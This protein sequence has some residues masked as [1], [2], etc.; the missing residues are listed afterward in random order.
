MTNLKTLVVRI[1]ADSPSRRSFQDSQGFL[2][3]TPFVVGTMAQLLINTRQKV[4]VRLEG[5]AQSP[6]ADGS[7]HD[8]DVYMTNPL[9]MKNI[10]N[11][12]FENHKRRIQTLSISERSLKK[13][14]RALWLIQGTDRRFRSSRSS[15]GT[16]NYENPAT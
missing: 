11:I 1:Q 6:K 16:E 3:L 14:F 8:G 7:F 9:M 10:E 2:T 5:R 4:S 13:I 12:D 15:A